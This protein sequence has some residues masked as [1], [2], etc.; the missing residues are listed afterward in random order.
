VQG[1]YL[2]PASLAAS[3]VP[4][5]AASEVPLLAASR[6]PLLAASRV[7]LQLAPLGFEHLGRELEGL[8]TRGDKLT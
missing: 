4:L 8:S 6:V 1:F 2:E 5:L 3:Q 7:P